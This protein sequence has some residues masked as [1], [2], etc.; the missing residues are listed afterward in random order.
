MFNVHFPLQR[1]GAQ[2][3][4]DHIKMAFIGLYGKLRDWDKVPEGFS[5]IRMRHQDLTSSFARS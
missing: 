1:D 4:D 2:H 5:Q 3:S